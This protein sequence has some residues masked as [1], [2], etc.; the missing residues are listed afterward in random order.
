MLALYWICSVF[1]FLFF[2]QSIHLIW[3]PQKK[4]KEKWRK[5]YWQ[6]NG[7]NR[8]KLVLLKSSNQNSVVRACRKCENK[9]KSTNIQYLKCLAK[10]WN[11]EREW[12]K[13]N[14]RLKHLLLLPISNFFFSLSVSFQF[15]NINNRFMYNFT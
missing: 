13:L 8:I 9:N 11:T 2:A 4:Q 10:R 5:K 14:D 12:N 6:G 7:S 15:Q 3:K 1:L